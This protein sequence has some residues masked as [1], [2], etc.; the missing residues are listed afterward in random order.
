[1]AYSILD[2]ALMVLREG[3]EVLLLVVVLMGSIKLGDNQKGREWIWVGVGLGLLMSFA[4]GF[5]AWSFLRQES[6]DSTEMV[7]GWMSLIACLLLLYMS[8]WLHNH[9][10][11][12]KWRKFLE[13]E[14]A[15]AIEKGSGWLIGLLAFFAV[16]RE[17]AEMVI[18]FI[19]MAPAITSENLLL[20]L[21]LGLTFVF[22][23]G[24]VF[25]R[26]GLKIPVRIFFRLS[27][28]FVYYLSFKFLG[29]GIH[30]LQQ[31]GAL[32]LTSIPW[33]PEI[34]WIAIYPT[35]ESM[36]PQTLLV[37]STLFLLFW[38]RKS[39]GIVSDNGIK[40]DRD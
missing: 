4:L 6:A 11:Q 22:V 35:W 27:S 12:S 21:L 24:A 34:E 9:A 20:G 19:G 38:N 29:M 10:S 26:M 7:T 30:S 2:A 37:V 14:T 40:I 33:L 16:L 1:M 23:L 36:I 8:Y 15:A 3:M 28:I 18:F 25:L 5:Y 32:P 13:E 31:T 17:G 39:E